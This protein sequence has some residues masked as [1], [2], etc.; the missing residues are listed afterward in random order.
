MPAP[1]P[2]AIPI[3]SPVTQLPYILGPAAAE[4]TLFG[5]VFL[6]LSLQ[7]EA[8][9]L[10]TAACWPRGSPAQHPSAKRPRPAAS[11]AGHPRAQ[12]CPSSSLGTGH[13]GMGVGSSPPCSG[14]P[15]KW[16]G[17]EAPGCLGFGVAVVLCYACSVAVLAADANLV[18][19]LKCP[20]GGTRIDV[21]VPQPLS[22]VPPR[23]AV[24][25]CGTSVAPPGS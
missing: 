18:P 24:L 6:R 4:F 19:S 9:W 14:C 17:L 10:G 23:H 16:G 21:V 11:T 20:T 8:I 1:S 13:R 2:T 3:L 12:P 15:P 22:P 5:G 7:E 25:M